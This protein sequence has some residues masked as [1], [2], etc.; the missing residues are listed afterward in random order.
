MSVK[1]LLA[2][3]SPTVH[4][5]IKIILKEEPYEIIECSHEDKLAAL[6]S[7]H[8]FQMVFLDFNFSEKLSGYEIAKSIKKQSANSKVLVMYGT[9]DTVD[10]TLLRDAQVEQFVVKPFDTSK[11][12]SQVKSLAQGIS[13]DFPA[14][15]LS[16]DAWTIQE[17][18]KPEIQ[19]LPVSRSI[20]ED[21][22][23]WG[24]A[25]PAVIGE[26]DEQAELPPV[27]EPASFESA[28][29]MESVATEK[30]VLEKQQ[31]SHKVVLPADDDLAYP[32]LSTLSLDLENTH[33]ASSKLTSIDDLNLNDSD[34]LGSGDLLELSQMDDSE[35]IQKIEDQIRDEVEA[36]LWRVDTLED[37]TPRL[38]VVKDR[39][40]DELSFSATSVLATMDG[41]E[42]F[43][44]NIF[45]KINENEAPTPYS[46]HEQTRNKTLKGEVPSAASFN[47]EDLRPL[48]K[49]MINQAV[50]D[51]CRQHI[52]KVA[53]EV[54]P[55]LAENLIKSELKKIS[56]KV[57]R[58]L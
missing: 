33:K 6:L 1:I 24:M 51:Y 52:D 56:D 27:I 58:D 9:F 19:A 57:S 34:S 29:K 10:E 42:S 38:S 23:E 22:S 20:A 43:D 28:F 50:A 44:E 11:F 31:K 18:K 13:Q 3:D 14:E 37:S 46:P 21:L 26:G 41:G 35:N 4:K 32:D 12:K 15:I 25:I 8:Q 49:E 17:D 45:S 36:D 47:I 16:D 2:D 30:P 48:I 55:D 7:K 39:E 54:I 40:E 53:W 5:V